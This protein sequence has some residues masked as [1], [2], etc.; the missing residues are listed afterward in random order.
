MLFNS[1]D[2]FVFMVVVLF[3]VWLFKKREFQFMILIL[4]SYYF[5]YFSSG[6]FLV[7]LLFSSVLDFYCGR[8]IFETEVRGRKRRFL[9]MSL[10]GNLGILAFFKYMDFGIESV[11]YILNLMGVNAS[12]E[13][14]GIFLPIG[15]SFFTFQT[16]SYT[17]DIYFGKLNPS[18]S[19][20]KFML[21][22][23]FFPQLV[24]GPIVRAKD[25]LPQLNKYIS[26]TYKNLKFGISLIGWGLVK[27]IVFADNIAPLVNV[28]FEDPT[29]WGSFLIILG[30]I[31]FGIQIYCDFSGY[32]DIAIGTARILGFKI[33]MNFN[34]PYFSKSPAD[35]WRRWHIS[36]SSWLKDYL[37][38]PL[39]G[40]RKGKS[41][42]Y[43]NLMATMVLGGLWHGAAWN[44]V[45][46]G[47]YQ[48][49]VLGVHRFLAGKLE[50]FKGFFKGEFGSLIAL[51]LTQYL[52]FLGWLI[53]RV[54]EGND[55]IYSIKKFIFIDFSLV[56]VMDFLLMY[57]TSV[58]FILVFVYLHYA[59]YSFKDVL[60]R[61]RFLKL[62][63]WL[64][65]IVI[66]VVLILIF[67][68]SE[69]AEFIYF[70]F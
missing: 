68:P 60:E 47:F 13:L 40:N 45:A 37:Y 15:I 11:N 4:G 26:F 43:F 8:K 34:K 20:L 23:A 41:R 54:K 50:R 29:G 2:F 63:Y 39:G 58:I 35:F 31:G 12:F 64:I 5:Y 19:F 6:W 22:V 62:R 70:Q 56:N 52:V 18:N 25:F 65:Y 53:F 27:K 69:T 21:Y 46:W 32:S 67:S 10:I 38:I 14:L 66:V 49:G 3:L 42:T 28:I 57:K 7:L 44:F 33:P 51:G 48:G 1:L 55:L 36:L 16:M 30:A 17:L 9:V 59:S 61:I 24:A